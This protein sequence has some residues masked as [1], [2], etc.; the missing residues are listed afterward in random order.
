VLDAAIPQLFGQGSV[1][2]VRFHPERVGLN[3]RWISRAMSD[4]LGGVPAAHSRHR[5]TLLTIISGNNQTGLPDNPTA[6]PFDVL[7]Y[8]MLPAPRHLPNAPVTFIVQQRRRQTGAG[9]L[10]APALFPKLP[11]THRP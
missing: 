6:Q 11:L 10:G 1:E 9:H 3:D 5:S 4:M 8:G 2:L 7:R